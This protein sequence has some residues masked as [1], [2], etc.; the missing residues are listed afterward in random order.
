M[1]AL[2][3]FKPGEFD[4]QLCQISIFV[5]LVSFHTLIMQTKILLYYEIHS[6]QMIL[7]LRMLKFSQIILDA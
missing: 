6:K 7:P 3:M 2:R 4:E 5:S 1:K